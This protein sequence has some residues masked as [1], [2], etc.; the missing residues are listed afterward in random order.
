M[1]AMSAR[2][3]ATPGWWTKLNETTTLDLWRANELASG[4]EPAAV[5]YVLAEL[6]RYVKL[7]DA[8]S[9][10]EV[11]VLLAIRLALVLMNGYSH[12]GCLL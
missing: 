5:D 1:C 6:E 3:R 7:R 11:C 4:S 12:P 8:S 10:I 9:G 2:I